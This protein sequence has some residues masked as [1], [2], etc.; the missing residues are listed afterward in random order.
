MR[1]R[2]NC[3]NRINLSDFYCTKCG[4]KGLTLPRKDGRLKEKGH[5]KKLYCLHC[6]EENNHVE[7]KNCG[8]YTYQDFYDEFTL[9]RFI[10]G[11]R[12]PLE[13]LLGCSKTSCQYNIEG[14]CWNANFSY[15]C[16]HRQK[17][18]DI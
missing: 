4:Q 11:E 8:S 6:K 1:R 2:R 10:N 3:G 17:K 16:R 18:G 14:K 15:D 12:V 9:G 7:I 13:D 5:L